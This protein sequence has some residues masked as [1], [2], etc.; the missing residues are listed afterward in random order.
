MG[1][2]LFDDGLSITEKQLVSI[3]DYGNFNPGT[4]LQGHSLEQGLFKA[5]PIHLGNHCCLEPNAFVHYGVDIGAG[6]RI[7]T[8]AFVMK[9]EQISAGAYWCGNPAQPAD[10]RAVSLP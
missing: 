9:G 5:E 6:A 3:G 10:R 2:M 4:V 8:D 1:K 7:G